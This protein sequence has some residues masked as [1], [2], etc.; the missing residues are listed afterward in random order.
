MK[1][2]LLMGLFLILSGCSLQS[3]KNHLI[4]IQKR[5]I[6]SLEHQLQK[7]SMEVDQ[8][9]VKHLI[10]ESY[11]ES[12][13]KELASLKEL[14]KKK[15]WIPALRKSQHLKKKYPNSTRLHYYRYKILKRIG[16][17]QQALK[18]KRR[19]KDLRAKN[20]KSP[21]REQQEQ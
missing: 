2:C 3:K 21:E 12:E 9:K 8:L 15:N 5:R 1:Y 13:K 6:K 20:S 7:K 17:K 4:S 10:K 16:L 19:M 14:I 11:L 18:E